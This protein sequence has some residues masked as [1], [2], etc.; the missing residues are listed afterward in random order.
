MP[1][2]TKSAGQNKTVNPLSSGMGPGK[3]MPS[4]STGNPDDQA[5]RN[6]MLAYAN[7]PKY[8]Q[9]LS[10]FY[11]YPDYVQSQRSNVLQ[12]VKFTEMPNGKT[13]YYPN[14]EI[15]ISQPELDAAKISRGEGVTH[16]LAH[17]VNQNADIKAAALS[18]LES[19][20]IMKRTKGLLPDV[21]ESLLRSSKESGKPLSRIMGGEMHDVDPAENA[22]DIQAL[23]FLL[24][25]RKIYDAGAQDVTPD[26]L[27]KAAK[28][29]IIRGSFIYKRLKNA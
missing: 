3:G 4:T 9:R 13:Q 27:K 16:E 8:K 14:N 26:V 20:Y 15:T 1:A 7:S 11:K 17:A 23:R 6:W 2:P 22:S 29:P 21:A 10:A 24:N 12:G 5:A 28:D 18:P 25:K 19:R